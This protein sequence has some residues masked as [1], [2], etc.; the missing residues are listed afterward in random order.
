[1]H[2]EIYEIISTGQW[3]LTP[4]ELQTDFLA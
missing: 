4:I 3:K 1:L 2:E